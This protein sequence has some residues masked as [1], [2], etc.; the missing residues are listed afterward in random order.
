[1]I[2]ANGG[3]PAHRYTPQVTPRWPRG[4][5]PASVGLPPDFRGPYGEAHIQLAKDYKPKWQKPFHLTGEREEVMKALVDDLIQKHFIEEC[6][7]GLWANNAFPV[8]K[9]GFKARIP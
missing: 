5:E 4:S 1:M 8:P 2:S 6:H 7:S 9:P 3:L